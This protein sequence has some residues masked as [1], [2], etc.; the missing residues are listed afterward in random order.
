MK[1]WSY[2]SLTKFETCP[3]QFYR[4]KVLKDVVEPPTEATEWGTKVHEALEFRVRDKTPLP[5]WAS[6]WE[7]IAR[8]FDKF[9]GRTFCELELGL[10]KN[11]KPTGFFD[12]DCWY[13]GI[14]DVGVDGVVSFLGDYKTGKV[15]D[16]HDQLK[17]FAATYMSAKPHVERCKTAYLWLK[18]DKVTQKEFRREE[19]PV[20]WQEFLPRVARMEAAF[21]TDKW[22]K[23][24]SGLCRGWCPVHDCDFWRPKRTNK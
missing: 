20:I 19:V 3:F 11:F 13:R 14:I 17:L 9:G 10:T 12:D 21:N 6:Q 5:D 15:K 18:H 22:V 24:P 4:C 7:P 23:K 2:S 8:Q 16:D 1:A